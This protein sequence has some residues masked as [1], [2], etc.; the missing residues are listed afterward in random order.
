[1]VVKLYACVLGTVLQSQGGGEVPGVAS[2]RVRR[3][4]WVCAEDVPL[5]HRG[6]L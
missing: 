2:V 3:G 1:M 4:A 5:G 6:R